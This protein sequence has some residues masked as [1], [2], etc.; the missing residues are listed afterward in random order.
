MSTCNIRIMVPINGNDWIGH[1]DL[2][3]GGEW[4]FGD[5]NFINPV[6][7]YENDGKLHVFEHQHSFAHYDAK[8]PFE[9][10]YCSFPADT[11]QVRSCLRN[12]EA[13]V[14]SGPVLNNNHDYVYTLNNEFSE[15]SYREHNCFRATAIWCNWL[16]DNTL[17]QIYNRYTTN[18]EAY[19]PT[20]MKALYSSSWDY[21]GKIE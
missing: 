17:L 15:Y 2:H 21:Y 6:F 1:Y 10:W 4:F 13:C 5:R 3:L 11:N 7:S 19:K 8:K 18:Y 12:I 16:G 9:V 20:K 14:A